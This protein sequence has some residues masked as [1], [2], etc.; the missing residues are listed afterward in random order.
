MQEDGKII[1]GTWL[2]TDI[3]QEKWNQAKEPRTPSL[4]SASTAPAL[5]ECSC[6]L[7]PLQQANHSKVG[8]GRYPQRV[9]LKTSMWC[10]Q[11]GGCTAPGQLQL[12]HTGWPISAQLSWAHLCHTAVKCDLTPLL[13][14][15]SFNLLHYQVLQGKLSASRNNSSACVKT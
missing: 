4:C 14:F 6:H 12:L 8:K 3:L 11:E 10:L 15:L 5:W 13:A 9:F 2:N 7:L 1:Q